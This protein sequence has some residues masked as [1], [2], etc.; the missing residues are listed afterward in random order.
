MVGATL[1]MFLIF[2][3]EGSRKLA[4]FRFGTADFA[5]MREFKTFPVQIFVNTFYVYIFVSRIPENIF[6]ANTIFAGLDC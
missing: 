5:E 2:R 3:H 4:Q 6:R 1:L